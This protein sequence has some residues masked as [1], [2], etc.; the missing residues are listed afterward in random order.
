VAGELRRRPLPVVVSVGEPFRIVRVRPGLPDDDP[1]TSPCEA[2]SLIGAARAARRK[3]I[4]LTRVVIARPQT[5]GQPRKG[6]R[7][8]MG[9]DDE[10]SRHDLAKKG[11]DLFF[12]LVS[13][14]SPWSALLS[15]LYA[16]SDILLYF[17]DETCATSELP[18]LQRLSDHRA[19]PSGYCTGHEGFVSRCPLLPGRPECFVT[20]IDVDPGKSISSASVSI[21]IGPGIPR[22]ITDDA[23]SH[24]IQLHVSIAGQQISLRLNRTRSIAALP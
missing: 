17:I 5:T 18:P 8:A 11:T 1:G 22:R 19:L 3:D 16:P 14:R 24:R 23:R 6:Q 21:I 15:M 4:R 13:L 7:R 20:R 2:Y 12:F 10:R 9:L